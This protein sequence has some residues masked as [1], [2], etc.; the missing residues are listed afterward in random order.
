MTRKEREREKKAKQIRAIELDSAG[1]GRASIA[2]ELG[3]SSS[4]LYQW[5]RDLNVPSKDEIN[6]HPIEFV[7]DE[8]PLATELQETTKDILDPDYINSPEKLS[9][10]KKEAEVILKNI[11][12]AEGMTEQEKIKTFLGNAYLQHLRDMVGKL[13]PIKNVKD[14]ETYHKL[15]FQS[16]GMDGKETT[17][18]TKHIE[19]SILNNTKASKGK[20]VTIK[21]RKVIDV[22]VEEQDS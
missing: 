13:P 11:D 8:D 6:R 5:F 18:S 12:E 7:E 1:W 19:I 4:T 9:A 10:H 2:R 3:I 20:A 14:L 21:P 17:R 15:L 16:F 22:E